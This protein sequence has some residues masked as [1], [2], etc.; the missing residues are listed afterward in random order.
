MA[1]IATIH[2]HTCGETKREAR[3]SSDYSNVCYDCQAKASSKAERE[4]KAGREGLTL[5]ERIRDL[6]NF[7]YHHGSHDFSPT[8][9]G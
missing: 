7:M 9:Y 1:Y 6:E 2:C 8:L 5:E 3:R 4:W